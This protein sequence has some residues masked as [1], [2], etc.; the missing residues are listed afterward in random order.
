MIRKHQSQV[1][2]FG[3][4]R[5]RER[6][7]ISSSASPGTSCGS[8]C[9]ELS[10]F[11]DLLSSRGRANSG[12][13]LGTSMEDGRKRKGSDALLVL[14]LLPNTSGFGPSHITIFPPSELRENL[15]RSIIRCLSTSSSLLG[16]T[17]S[18]T[19]IS[20]RFGFPSGVAR[21]ARVGFA[22]VWG[23][24]GGGTSL[25]VGGGA[26]RS[27]VVDGG[28]R[29]GGGGGRSSVI[30]GGGRD[31]GGGASSVFSDGGGRD[32]GGSTSLIRPRVSSA[33]LHFLLVVLLL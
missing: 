5:R 2:D 1:H 23:E 21:T 22:S 24:V 18:G 7:S 29:D 13:G 30:G 15:S 26:G 6:A 9:P 31:G 16:F 25:V 17:K 19:R 20:F 27:S 10:S 32:G 14:P 3:K 12:A 11:P 28:G 33:I 8:L 4:P